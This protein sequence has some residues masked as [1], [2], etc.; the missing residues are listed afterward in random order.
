[1]KFISKHRFLGDLIQNVFQC[2][3]TWDQYEQIHCI[4]GAASTYQ[5]PYRQERV[6]EWRWHIHIRAIQNLI[7]TNQNYK[8]A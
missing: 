4:I 7:R 1:M 3:L 2:L 8:S 5:F 6:D